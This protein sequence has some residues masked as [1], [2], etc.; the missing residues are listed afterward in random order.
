MFL[1]CQLN[2]GEFSDA[3]QKRVCTL[4]RSLGCIHRLPE[5]SSGAG[6]PERVALVHGEF[7]GAAG[8]SDGDGRVGGLTFRRPEAEA[9]QV[10]ARTRERAAESERGLPKDTSSRC[11]RRGRITINRPKS[12]WGVLPMAL[13]ELENRVASLETQVYDAHQNDPPLLR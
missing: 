2:S 13:R 1:A 3:A 5:L 7:R 11:P 9:D 8:V 6:W 4:G 12:N 10:A